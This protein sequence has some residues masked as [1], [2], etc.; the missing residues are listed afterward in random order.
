MGPAGRELVAYAGQLAPAP[1]PHD[2]GT[3]RRA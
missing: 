3:G 2:S 1:A